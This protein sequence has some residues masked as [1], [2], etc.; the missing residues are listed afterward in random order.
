MTRS[1]PALV[2]AILSLLGA[3]ACAA[4]PDGDVPPRA[5][6]AD[7]AWMRGYWSGAGPRAGQQLEEQWLMPG[8]DSIAGLIRISQNGATRLIELVLIEQD[9]ESLSLRVRQWLP[10]FV[11]AGSG[12]P[13][14]MK[15]VT[16]GE[17]HA[18]FEATAPG[19]LTSLAYRRLAADSFGVTAHTADGQVLD[20]VLS[21]RE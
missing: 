11:A 12:E 17:Q 15:L 1:L 3:T 19:A 21:R 4:S 5:R 14:V 10:G 9:G 18:G 16:I 6:V 8:A 20:L 13:M 7:L 2:L